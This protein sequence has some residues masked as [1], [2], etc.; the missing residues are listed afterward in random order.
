MS[1]TTIRQLREGFG[2]T[3]VELAARLSVTQQY[4]SKVEKAGRIGELTR[5]RF[6]RAISEIAYERMPAA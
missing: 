1:G 6:E 3:Q 5:R 2:I 4:V